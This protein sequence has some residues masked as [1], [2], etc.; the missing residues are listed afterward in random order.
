VRQG[1]AH[2]KGGTRS[3]KQEAAGADSGRSSRSRRCVFGEQKGAAQG[4]ESTA[5]SFCRLLTCANVSERER[6]HK[7]LITVQCQRDQTRGHDIRTCEGRPPSAAIRAPR[8]TL[9]P[10][11]GCTMLDRGLH[12]RA[13]ASDEHTRL[14]PAG[15]VRKTDMW[16]SRPGLCRHSTRLQ[17]SSLPALYGGPPAGWGQS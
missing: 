12:L 10:D 14:L 17:C 6:S 16:G 7:H 9:K 5:T 3:S 13:Y 15:L 8:H 1:P 11:A 2:L 4:P